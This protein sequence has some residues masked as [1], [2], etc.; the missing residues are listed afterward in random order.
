MNDFSSVGQKSKYI[1]QGEFAVDAGPNGKIT[2][3]LGSCVATC[4]WDPEA[5]V[6]G[7]N[8]ILLPDSVGNDAE[9]SSLGAN[10]ME[11]LING[12]IRLGANKNNLRAKVFGGAAMYKG[13]TS[14]G[15]QNGTFVLDYLEREHIPCDGQSLGGS[16]ARRI[17]FIPATGQARQ[18]F[19]ED[20]PIEKVAPKPV[21]VPSNDLELF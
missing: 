20:V 14:A 3:I 8:H 15:D 19:V 6:G 12:L 5:R 13:L 9:F 7:M 16:K 18:K 1:A 10:S 2:T 4:L 11:L 17:E 21:E